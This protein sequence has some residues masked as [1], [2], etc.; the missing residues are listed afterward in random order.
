MSSD[1]PLLQEIQKGESQTLEFK[2]QLPKGQQVAKTLIAFANT[3]GGK[4]VVGVSDD[5]QL[6]GIQDDIF[7][8]QDQI[9][10]MINELCMPNILPYI[11]IENIQGIELL[12]IEVSRGSLLPYY[13]K[14]QGKAQG[15]Y[16]RLGA[17]NRVASPEYIQQLELQRL[18]QTFDE[19]PN[20]QYS[21]DDID[22]QPL[23]QAF[24]E[25]GKELSLQKMRNLK[26]IIQQN[27]QDYPSHGLLILLGL[28]EQVEIKCSRFKGTTMTVF[29]D[30]K[31]AT[32][33]DIIRQL[34]FHAGKM[35][36]K[37]LAEQVGLTQNALKDYLAD[38]VQM[39]QTLGE[40]FELTLEAKEVRLAFSS[41]INLNK[42]LLTYLNSSLGYQILEFVFKHK[43]F[44]T[45][46]L[47]QEF[48]SSEATIFRKLRDLNNSLRIFNI[49]IKNGQLVGD[50]LQIRYFYY[51]FY[52]LVDS[53]FSSTD[54]AVTKL[55][56]QLQPEFQQS[57]SKIA[58][59]RMGCWLFVTR[60][61]L[62]VANS[63]Y[64]RLTQIHDRFEA[65]QLYQMI[66][67]IIPE[68][69][70]QTVNFVGKYEGAMFYCFLITFDIIGEDNIKIK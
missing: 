27:G 55:M 63:D 19:Q 15:T 32:Q 22:L 13:L 14:P 36:S 57:F 70:Q 45:F 7:E 42:I 5:R 4:L 58:R 59:K 60:H 67:N 54:L 24:A 43:K 2:E 31:E 47:T 62:Q 6:V 23:K 65:D 35:P 37:A 21:L 26:L 1:H 41:D 25:V 33:I 20:P 48:S 66:Q 68:Y 17:S 61:R 39:C 9:T 38:I 69:F 50:E 8:L 18:N 56:A 28:Y 52:L 64:T 30:K 3:S 53:G 51:Q 10:S 11:Y 29:L 40:R 44:S 34:L 16:I 12:V 46:Q 49:G